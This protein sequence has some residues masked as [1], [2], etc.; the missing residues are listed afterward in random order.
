MS[1][2][3]K[4]R[5]VG[6]LALVL[7]VGAAS[8]TRSAG[9][10]TGAV[11]PR[12]E[13]PSQNDPPEAT[14]N[15]SAQEPGP[16]GLVR[17]PAPE[18]VARA[19]RPAPSR[20]QDERRAPRAGG[21]TRG[22]GDAGDRWLALG[23]AAV[24]RG[25]PARALEHYRAARRELPEHPAPLVGI[26]AA[27][28][29]KLGL[30]TEFGVAPGDSRVKELLSL[31]DRAARLDPGYPEQLLERGQLLLV[32]GEA[33]LAESV[34]EQALQRLPEDPEAHSALAIAR[35]ARGDVAQALTGFQEASRLDP[36]NP[37]RLT[38][39]GTGWMMS[40]EIDQALAAYQRAQALAPRDPQSAGNL[41]TALLASGRVDA[42]ITKL[43]EAHALAP[44][45]ATFMSN[46]AY[47]HQ[48]R[49]NLDLAVE[50]CE[51]ALS[52]DPKLGSAWINLGLARAA[53]GRLD[54]AEKAFRQALRLDPSD[55]R[56]QANLQDLADLRRRGR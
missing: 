51:K 34:L 6:G 2:G 38:N 22:V 30:P 21:L 1:L 19:P 28:F 16:P 48:L 31:L 39:L 52:A 8:C 53:Q 44:T 5:F 15:A 18:L 54:D 43:L 49:G 35:L 4:G 27:R 25:D 12:S 13:Q 36:N 20:Q 41:G 24:S 26:V 42:A 23:D 29:A 40:G 46:L 17:S 7:G 11:P 45:R 32:L 56:A 3:V 55:P 47:A 33:E 37:E 14:R 9:H 50:W 10:P